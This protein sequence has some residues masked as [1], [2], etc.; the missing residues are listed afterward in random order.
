MGLNPTF[1]GIW[2]ATSYKL[3]LLIARESVLILLFLE[4]GLR[5]DSPE[6]FQVKKVL[7]LNPTFS[8]IWSATGR[9]FG[10]NITTCQS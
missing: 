7:C 2:S 10:R 4:Y 3:S 8:G 9:S 6:L 5:L 1:S